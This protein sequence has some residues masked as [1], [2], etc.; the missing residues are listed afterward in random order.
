M[1]F[2]I[3]HIITGS[4]INVVIVLRLSQDCDKLNKMI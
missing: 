3:A 4:C 2:G 1:E